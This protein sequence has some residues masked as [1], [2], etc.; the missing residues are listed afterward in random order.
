MTGHLYYW[1]YMYTIVKVVAGTKMQNSFG[2]G[3]LGREG[4]LRKCLKEKANNLGLAVIV[5]AIIPI[6]Y[7]DIAFTNL[8]VVTCQLGE[9]RHHMATHK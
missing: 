7:I 5:L 1:E 8:C 2:A 9:T 4:E 6:D 3:S